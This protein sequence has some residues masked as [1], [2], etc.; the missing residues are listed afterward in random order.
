V[1]A[2][3]FVLA[4]PLVMEVLPD[5][6]DPNRITR[7][8]ESGTFRTR[9]L[10]DA[11]KLLEVLSNLSASEQMTHTS[12]RGALRTRHLAGILMPWRCYLISPTLN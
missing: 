11:F 5:L 3:L 7:T 1:R 4:N 2:V 9:C 10:S 6:S 8:T 12:E